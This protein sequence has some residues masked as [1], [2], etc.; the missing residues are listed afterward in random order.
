MDISTADLTQ[1][2]NLTLSSN[3]ERILA[4]QFDMMNGG[5]KNHEQ[6]AIRFSFL[7]APRS[8]KRIMTAFAFVS[9]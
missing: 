5:I 1:L 3:F 9:S 2:I 4:Y 6:N 8:R 7:I